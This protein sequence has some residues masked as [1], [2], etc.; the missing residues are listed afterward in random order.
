MNMVRSA[1]GM[2]A[3]MGAAVA[4]GAC[5]GGGGEEAASASSSDR[6]TEQDAAVKW[7]KCMRDN[8]IEVPDPQVGERGIRIR[9]RADR[10]TPP[11]KVERAQ[12]ECR[13]HLRGA[14]KPPSEAERAKMRDAA[15]KFA[16]CMRRNGVDMPDPD[17][18]GDGLLFRVGPGEGPNRDSATFRRAERECRG[19]LPGRP[20]APPNP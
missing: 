2:A 19:L 14:I 11:A 6:Q 12:R 8:G 4:L 20:G 5:G 10:D 1:A 13:E 18:S 7:A 15:L 3:A 16:Q 17:T 9:I